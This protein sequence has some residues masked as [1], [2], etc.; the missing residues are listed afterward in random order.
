MH[1]DDVVD[2]A[3]R[4]RRDD[5]GS[6]FFAYA[7]KSHEIFGGGV[8]DV[9]GVVLEKGEYVESATGVPTYYYLMR[10]WGR[11]VG[12]E[13]RLCPGCGG[14]WRT[15]IPPD[16]VK[17]FRDFTFQCPK[18]RLVSHMADSY[19]D[20]RHAGIGEWRKPKDKKC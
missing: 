1:L 20:D 8:I 2:V 15:E 5:G 4:P 17:R 19:D 14:A 10:Y 3:E 13:N 11:K 16:R 12:E 18:C 7:G 6:G 9:D